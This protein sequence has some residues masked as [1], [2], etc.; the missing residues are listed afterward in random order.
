VWCGVEGASWVDPSVGWL[1]RPVSDVDAEA[2]AEFLEL[3]AVDV[4]G[5]VEVFGFGDELEGV[6]SLEAEVFEDL[7]EGFEILGVDEEELVLVE[8][9]FHRA[10]RIKGGEAGTAVVKEERF[11]IVEGTFEDDGVH[12]LAIKVGVDPRL[13]LVRRLHDDVDLVT[14]R[15]ERSI[16]TSNRRSEETDAA[17]TGMVEP[18]SG[19]R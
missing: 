10:V 13:A 8:L 19:S 15:G 5:R 4:V 11:V 1:V 6:V 16:K 7:F 12:M 3:F 17:S 9:H 18:V 14:K 2:V